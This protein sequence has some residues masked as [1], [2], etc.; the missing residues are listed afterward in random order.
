MMAIAPP[1]NVSRCMSAWRVRGQAAASS[2]QSR[3]R[4]ASVKIRKQGDD[5]E[6]EGEG[7]NGGFGINFLTP[8]TRSSG[9]DRQELD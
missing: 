3:S 6:R 5:R 2:G 7:N 1:S 8:S 4:P 9:G